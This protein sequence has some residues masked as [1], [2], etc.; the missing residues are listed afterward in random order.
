MIGILKFLFFICLT[1][2]GQPTSNNGGLSQ[3]H[4]GQMEKTQVDTN[5]RRLF[6]DDSEEAFQIQVY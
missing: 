1:L 2:Q 3:G 5:N 6:L 4:I